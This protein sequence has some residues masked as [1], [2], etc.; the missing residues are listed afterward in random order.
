MHWQRSA[1]R[2][3][4]ALALHPPNLCGFLKGDMGTWGHGDIPFQKGP[5]K[6]REG[7]GG[8]GAEIFDFRCF[9][10]WAAPW[11]PGR[12]KT[13][14]FKPVSFILTYSEPELT[15][16]ST[17]PNVPCL[18]YPLMNLLIFCPGRIFRKPSKPKLAGSRNYLTHPEASYEKIKG[19][20]LKNQGFWGLRKDSWVVMTY[21]G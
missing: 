1:R 20:I 8:R 21:D 13:I 6:S 7:C 12:A 11:D 18:C 15:L 3:R 5:Y 4:A 10:P 19:R 17:F 14:C 16:D 2:C 9:G